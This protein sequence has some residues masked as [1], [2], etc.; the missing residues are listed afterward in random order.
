M[1]SFNGM[2]SLLILRNTMQRGF[3]YTSQPTH[4]PLLLFTH[5]GFWGRWKVGGEKGKSRKSRVAEATEK[6]ALPQGAGAPVAR[7]NRESH[8]CPAALRQPRTMSGPADPF[9]VASGHFPFVLCTVKT[10][11]LKFWGMERRNIIKGIE[12]NCSAAFNFLG[13]V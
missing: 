13:D 3:N 8:P 11:F 10:R 7:P 1:V 9:P 4:I 6:A 5:M 12:K 2:N